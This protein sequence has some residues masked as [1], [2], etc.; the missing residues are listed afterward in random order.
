MTVY[1]RYSRR[2]Q[3][4]TPVATNVSSA[5]PAT[6]LGVLSEPFRTWRSSN[7]TTPTA[8]VLDFGAAS[9]GAIKAFSFEGAN[10][11]SLL[12]EGNATDSWGTP[13]F[14][15]AVDVS[16]VN[17]WQGRRFKVHVSVASFSGSYRYA[18]LTPSSPAAGATYFELGSAAP[19]LG[20]EDVNE[21]FQMPYDHRPL[22]VT[23]TV[24]LGG[25][26]VRYGVP[27]SKF[28]QVSLGMGAFWFDNTPVANNQ[29][30][31]QELAL[32]PDGEVFLW[33]DYFL[34]SNHAF[35]VRRTGAVQMSSRATPQAVEVTGLEFTE[36]V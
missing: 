31:W 34:D 28:C 23:E 32:M 8:V 5:Y 13:S 11:S 2:A 17:T 35:H 22:S 36:V 20:L 30:Q 15:E 9:H 25:G 16:G 24:Q 6:N 33:W 14:S 26:T 21:Q 3:P 29:I 4:Y 27:G 12:V 10:F 18:R 19:W 1:W 7:V